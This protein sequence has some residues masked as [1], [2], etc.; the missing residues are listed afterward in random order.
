MIQEFIK[1]YVGITL[2]R[3]NIFGSNLYIIKVK[4]LLKNVKG[5]GVTPYSIIG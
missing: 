2:R 5:H 1:S 4:V 3:I